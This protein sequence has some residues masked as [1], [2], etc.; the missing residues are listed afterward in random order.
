LAGCVGS[1]GDG[2]DGTPRPGASDGPNGGSAPQAGLVTAA[3][4]RDLTRVATIHMPTHYDLESTIGYT[5]GIFGTS[6]SRDLTHK[7]NNASAPLWNDPA[8]MAMIKKVRITQ[9]QRFRSLIDHLDAVPET[10]GTTLLD[11]TV[12]L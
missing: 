11:H 7:T 9:A 6:D 1:I 10:D 4:S 2:G 5:G 12:V 8:A 3:F